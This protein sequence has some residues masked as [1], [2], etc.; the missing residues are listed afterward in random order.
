MTDTADSIFMKYTRHPWLP[1]GT[2]LSL[3]PYTSQ[4]WN[5]LCHLQSITRNRI[6][7]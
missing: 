7:L 2:R 3:C 4:T 5:T 6:S 1:L